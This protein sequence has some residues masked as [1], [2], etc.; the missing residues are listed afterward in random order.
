MD[1]FDKANLRLADRH[2]I[3]RADCLW[4]CAARALCGVRHGRHPPVQAGSADAPRQRHRDCPCAGGDSDR[5]HSHGAHAG[6]LCL[7]RHHAYRCSVVRRV[8]A[9]RARQRRH[10]DHSRIG[11]CAHAC[12]GRCG[13][14][15]REHARSHACHRCSAG[16]I[17]WRAI[18]CIVS[19]I[20]PCSRAY[21]PLPRHCATRART[22]WR[23][24]PH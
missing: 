9:R 8:P 2:W 6:E 24:V 16:R 19:R 5:W 17:R 21:N 15:D 22:G 23:C 3:G 14:G 10:H 4:R 20:R 11:L 7:Y 18:A 13:A 1:R 12:S